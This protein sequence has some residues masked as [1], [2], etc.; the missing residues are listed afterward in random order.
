[1]GSEP[2][3]RLKVYRIER[4]ALEA[5]YA[6]LIDNIFR[7]LTFRRITKKAVEAQADAL[8][9]GVTSRDVCL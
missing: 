1:M 8:I 6:Q 3:Y 4:T 9:R 5:Y 2:T 7:R